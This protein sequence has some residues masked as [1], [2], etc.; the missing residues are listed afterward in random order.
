MQESTTF[1]QWIKERRKR[2]DLTREEVARCASCSLATIEKL[3]TGE[4]R[5]SRQLAELVGKCLGIAPGDLAAFLS[6]ARGA[7]PLP[8]FAE[9][10]HIEGTGTPQAPR[11][12]VSLIS[13]PTAFVGREREVLEVRRRLLDADVRLLTLTGPPGIG[14][15]RLALEVAAGLG[16]GEF[17]DGIVFVPLATTTE[18]SMVPARIGQALGLRESGGRPVLEVLKE[19][20]RD[21][22]LLLVLDNFE[23][24]SEGGVHVGELLVSAPGLKA[25]VT[26]RTLLHTY[27]EHSFPVPAMSLPGRGGAHEVQSLAQYEAINLFVQRAKA[28]RHDFQLT[29]DNANAVAEI[30]RRLDGLPLA[31]ELAA[32]RARILTPELILERLGNRLDLLV[33]GSSDLPARQR[34]LR[35]AIEWSY[36]SLDAGEQALFR[37]MSVFAGGC[38][39]EAVEAVSSH[40]VGHAGELREG[41]NGTTAN[42]RTPNLIEGLSSLAGKSLL[43]VNETGGETRFSMLE[44]LREYASERLEGAEREEATKAHAAYFLRLAEQS[45][46]GLLA[47]EQ[48]V[49]LARL[50]REHDNLRA[51][52]A[53]L[54]EMGEAETAARLAGALRRF[55]Y[56]RGHISEGR[57]WLE[58]VLEAR[59]KLPVAV[60]AK[61]LHGVGTLAW[62]QGDN[63]TAGRLFAESLDLWRQSG[64]RQGVAHMLNNLGIV[65]LPQG[66]YQTAH[67]MHTEALALYQELG[68]EWSIALS[69]ANLG[70]VALN[71][72]QYREAERLLTRSLRLRRQIGDQ[73]GIAQSLNNL[74]I[75][76]R[77][78]GRLSEAESLHRGCLAMF[79]ELG[80]KWNIAMALANQ[81]HVALA[82][83]ETEEARLLFGDGLELSCALGL[84][85]GVLS[86]LEGLAMIAA[87]L[88]NFEQAP[89]L[90]GAA[91]GIREA[92]GTPIPPYETA[93]YDYYRAASEASLGE[94]AFSV[95]HE[96]GK[97]MSLEQVCAVADSIV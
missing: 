41:G 92:L 69:F 71:R 15:T 36:S 4:R 66:D 3:E 73:Q 63:S 51:A 50:E 25:L 48:G 88:G 80:D 86:C 33:G 76:M 46:V 96:E 10:S 21:K 97:T 64:D 11:L 17:A 62:S 94:E 28:A 38:T 85:Q 52:L 61:T 70:L 78:Q 47:R 30:C 54:L 12:V 32:I 91:E 77:C 67:V 29:S 37:Y 35:G 7:S 79:R 2:L 9:T 1:G 55:W 53:R 84:K 45:E 27:G 74:G 95:A 14:K 89:T 90:F 56:L 22:R 57:Q 8:D 26:S 65:A 6:F 19:W 44:T 43:Q 81:G 23:Q 42:P 58:R 31:I 59:E 5:P 87:R 75:V 68:D 13:P 20:L 83:G 24:V 16:T 93:D 40:V 60:Q 18:P 49:W 82:S 34:S 39:L 72:G